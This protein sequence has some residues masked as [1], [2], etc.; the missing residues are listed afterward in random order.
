MQPGD[1]IRCFASQEKIVIK[2][3]Y[4][5]CENENCN[6]DIGLRSGLAA[7]L[8]FDKLEAVNSY[9]Q[10]C[11]KGCLLKFRTNPQSKDTYPCSRCERVEP[12]RVGYF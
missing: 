4:F 6:Y 5:R 9:S 3:G 11:P 2:D 8:D 7:G 1:D 10:R 12:E